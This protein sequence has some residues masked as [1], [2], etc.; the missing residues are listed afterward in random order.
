LVLLAFGCARSA[1]TSSETAHSVEGQVWSP[2]CP[3]RLLID[4]TTTQA[5]ELRADIQQRIDRGQTGEQVI[6]WVRTEFGDE[7]IA[8]PPSTGWGLMVWLVPALIFLAGGAVLVRV[9]VRGRAPSPG[10]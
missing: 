8:R 3:G 1:T 4:C 9:L 6:A 10:G 2:Y 5:R 7:A